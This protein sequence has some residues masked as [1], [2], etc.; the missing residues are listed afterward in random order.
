M[1]IFMKNP[2]SK[3]CACAVMN[4]CRNSVRSAT[5]MSVMAA[6][7]MK[8]IANQAKAVRMKKRGT[9]GIMRN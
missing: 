5:L 2:T 8:P 1:T 9:S 3:M 7:Q 6:A 4:A